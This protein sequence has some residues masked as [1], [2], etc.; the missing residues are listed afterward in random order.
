MANTPAN[1]LE[2]RGGNMRTRISN[3]ATPCHHLLVHD[4][5]RPC[6][7]FVDLTAEN[8]RVLSACVAASYYLFQSEG[9]PIGVMQCSDDA[10]EAEAVA[11]QAELY[12]TSGRVPAAEMAVMY[13]T[14]AQSR[15][16]EEA[17]VRKALP[18]VVVGAQ[19]FYDRREVCD[20]RR[21]RED[22]AVLSPVL[23]PCPHRLLPSPCFGSLGSDGAQV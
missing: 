7:C 19:R 14:N 23:C 17:F 10:G 11:R 2:S 12:L 20:S 5:L 3:A 16:F 9:R 15:S 8:A 6:S 4:I 21:C 13:R 1:S 22:V 18:F